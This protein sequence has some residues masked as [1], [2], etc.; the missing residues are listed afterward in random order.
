MGFVSSELRGKFDGGCLC[1]CWKVVCVCREEFAK[2]LASAAWR[3]LASA[4]D[5]M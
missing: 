2:V 1:H 5:T 4:A 3:N